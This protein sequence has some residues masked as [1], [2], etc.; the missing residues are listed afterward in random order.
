MK[1]DCV[2]EFVVP[3]ACE[4]REACENTRHGWLICQQV[5]AD[6]INDKDT[7][8][9][10]HWEEITDNDKQ[11]EK[12]LPEIPSVGAAAPSRSGHQRIGNH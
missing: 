11:Q 3:V 10:A 9:T 5:A 2:Y 1:N 8:S 7:A 4:A 6:Q 12:M